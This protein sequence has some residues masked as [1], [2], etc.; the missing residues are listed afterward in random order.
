ML[1]FYYS[2]VIYVFFDLY[3][4]QLLSLLNHYIAEQDKGIKSRLEKE[5]VF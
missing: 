1:S 4:N 3:I 2:C 5:N